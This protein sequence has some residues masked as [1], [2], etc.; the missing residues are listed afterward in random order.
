LKGLKI[1]I[2]V[3]AGVTKWGYTFSIMGLQNPVFDP[4]HRDKKTPEISR[5]APKIGLIEVGNCPI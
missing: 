3:T 2:A 1:R 5:I 4:L